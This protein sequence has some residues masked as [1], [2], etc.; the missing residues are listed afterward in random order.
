MFEK[1]AKEYANEYWVG[2]VDSDDKDCLQG[3]YQDGA[4]FGYKK[5]IEEAK[6]YH[7]S[8]LLYSI[9]LM[10]MKRIFSIILHKQKHF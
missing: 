10:K 7:V 2:L 8:A 4:E 9:K 6:N 5:G 3:A 1:A